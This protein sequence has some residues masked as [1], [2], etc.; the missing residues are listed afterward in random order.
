MKT[1][2]IASWPDYGR[3]IIV[4]CDNGQIYTLPVLEDGRLIGTEWLPFGPPIPGSEAAITQ[5]TTEIGQ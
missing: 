2:P 3:G 4:V 1:Y 5:A